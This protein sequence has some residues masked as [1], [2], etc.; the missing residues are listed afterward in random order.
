MKNVS[1]ALNAVLLLAVAVLYYFQFSGSKSAS[2]SSEPTTLSHIA[3]I[4][5]DSVLKYYEFTKVN[6]EKLQDRAKRLQDDLK[7][8]ATSLQGEINDYQRNRASLTIGQAQA[9]E[10]GLA[11]KEQNFRMAQETAGQEIQMEQAKLSQDLYDKITA[12]LKK[13]SQENGL[14]VVL[15]LDGTSDLWYG[16][17]SL[18]ISKQ[19]IEGLNAEYKAGTET[20]ARKDTTATKK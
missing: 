10:E 12:Y 11:R 6:N 3:Y 14:Q 17:D 1:L 18:D 4:N 5:T 13:Y 19:V 15:K 7:S 8:R 2:P 16:A 20:P 9:V